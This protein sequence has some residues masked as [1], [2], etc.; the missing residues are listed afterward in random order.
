MDASEIYPRRI[1]A[2][3]VFISQKGQT[4]MFPVADG[5]AKLSGRDCEFR[6]PSPRRERTV[7][8]EDLSGELQGEPGESLNRKNQKMTLKPVPTSEVIYRH[9]SK[10]RVQL[11][12]PKEETFPIPL[13]YIDVARSTHTDLD[14]V[15]EKRI[16][17]YCNVDSNRSLSDSFE[18][19]TKK[20]SIGKKNLPRDIWSGERLTKVQ[21]TARPFMCG[22]ENGAKLEKP[23]RN[24]KNMNGKT[25]SPN[26]TMLDD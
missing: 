9:H 8:S 13:K 17:D 19:F 23:L 5:T 6:E 11:N 21:T 2:K 20:H 16:A 14:V 22:L 12:V 15:Q 1:N 18:G 10:P 25:S 24:E 7:R 26:S 3:E 4:F